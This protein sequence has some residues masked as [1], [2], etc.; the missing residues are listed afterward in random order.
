[1]G[2]RSIRWLDVT[3]FLSLFVCENEYENQSRQ[4]RENLSVD[5]QMEPPGWPGCAEYHGPTTGVH[6]V[7][8]VYIQDIENEVESV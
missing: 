1:M 6:S 2:G 5:S 7:V 4:E 8:K 3:S